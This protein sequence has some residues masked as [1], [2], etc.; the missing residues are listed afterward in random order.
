MEICKANYLTKV[1]TRMKLL[2]TSI[3]LISI[4]YGYGQEAKVSTDKAEYKF[5]EIIELTFEVNAKFDSIDIPD[6]EGFK[7]I[8]G[9]SKSSSVSVKNGVRTENETRTYRLRP[10]ESGQLNINSPTFYKDGKEI[11]GKAVKVK[12]DPS[13]LTDR[14]LKEKEFKNFIEEGI[15]PKGTTRIILYEN[16]GYVEIFGEMGWEFHRRLTN[17]EVEQLEKVK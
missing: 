6:F 1:E 8:G 14:E 13:N 10:N 5:D 7:I 9:P 2:I 12:V 17:E 16:K 3:F 11:K 4:G 15:K